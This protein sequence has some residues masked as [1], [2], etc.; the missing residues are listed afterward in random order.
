MRQRSGKP[1]TGEGHVAHH[2]GELGFGGLETVRLTD[3][4]LALDGV[5]VAGGDSEVVA[6]AH[7]EIGWLVGGI[8]G[9]RAG[10]SGRSGDW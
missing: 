5:V 1:E 7:G 6:K 10:I 9:K 4:G 2:G 3:V 8:Q